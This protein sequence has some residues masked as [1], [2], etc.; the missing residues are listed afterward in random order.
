MDSKMGQKIFLGTLVIFVLLVGFPSSVVDYNVLADEGSKSKSSSDT[1]SKSSPSST[2][3]TKSK[4]SPS[5]TKSKSS[6][7]DTKSKSSPS[8]TKSKSSPSDTKSKSSPSDTKSKTT[9]KI[10]QPKTKWE[11]TEKENSDY[12]SLFGDASI[13]IIKKTDDTYTS[14]LSLDGHRD[15]VKI[16]N[17][18]LPDE[19]TEMTIS[20]WVKPDYKNGSPEFTVASKQNSF[21]L[22]INNDSTQEKT[23]KF[24]IFD[25]IK[26]ITVETD[27]TVPSEEWTHI[28]AGLDKETVTIYVNGVPEST[29]LLSKTTHDDIEDSNLKSIYKTKSS[30][31]ILLGA[32]IES[33]S[34]KTY[35]TFSGLIE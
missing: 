25:G 20:T 22:T 18:N 7:S 19:I 24:S 2:S 23:A 13:E 27:S 30:S 3:D 15:F 26:W 32:N 9:D 4:S 14:T 8:D 33:T 35:N 31:D 28:A 34:S 1:K 16:K 17:T 5:D 6:P 21:A 12:L 11:L 10:I 29:K